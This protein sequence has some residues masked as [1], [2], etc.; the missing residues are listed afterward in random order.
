MKRFLA[1]VALF[2]VPVLLVC[3]VFRL[4]VYSSGEWRTEE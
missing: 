1:V 2:L 4:A 3:G